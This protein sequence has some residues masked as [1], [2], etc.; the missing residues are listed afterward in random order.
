MER[1]FYVLFQN[2]INNEL[3]FEVKEYNQGVMNSEP[4]MGSREE[5]E[6]WKRREELHVELVEKGKECILAE[7]EGYFDKTIWSRLSKQFAQTAILNCASFFDGYEGSFMNMSS[8][9]QNRVYN[10]ENSKRIEEICEMFNC[11]IRFCEKIFSG[12]VN[13]VKIFGKIKRHRNV[14]I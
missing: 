14:L 10:E 5:F 12:D 13:T 9:A 7:L 4:F 2:I 8:W 11:E 3:C 6:S 1:I